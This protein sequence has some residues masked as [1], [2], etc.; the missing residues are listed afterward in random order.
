MPTNYLRF[1]MQQFF[2]YDVVT[3]TF[4][5]GNRFDFSQRPTVRRKN[6]RPSVTPTATMKTL[7]THLLCGRLRIQRDALLFSKTP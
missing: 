3:N 5:A 1:N 4:H 7:R 6:R 2:R